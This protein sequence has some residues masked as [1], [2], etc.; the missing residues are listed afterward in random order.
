MGLAGRLSLYA[1]VHY[2]LTHPTA[3]TQISNCGKQIVDCQKNAIC[4][5][6]LSCLENC[7]PNDQAR[8]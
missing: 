5:A 4:K 8:H 2:V 1:Y 6:A 7:A 3:H